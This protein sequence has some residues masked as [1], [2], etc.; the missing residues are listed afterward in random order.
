M[1]VLLFTVVI[2]HALLFNIAKKKVANLYVLD[3][4]LEQEKGKEKKKLV[5]KVTFKKCIYLAVQG[6]NCG[7]WDL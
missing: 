1:L 3:E 5:P 2:S 7:M 6:L 4:P